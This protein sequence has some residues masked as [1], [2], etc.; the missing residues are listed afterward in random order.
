MATKVA[1]PKNTGGGGFVFEDDVCAW[2]LAS[3]LVGEPVF[4]ADCGAPVRL[5]FQT[6]PDG[7]FLDDVLVTTV[8]G[9]TRHRFALS[10]KSNVQFTATSAPSDFVAAAWEQ[11][12]SPMCWNLLA[13][14]PSCWRD[15]HDVS[16]WSRACSMR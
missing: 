5:D 3:M 11:W 15:A 1:P 16:S 9:A 7:W 6:R 12:L 4:G 2:L 13:P 14:A 10:V 8:V